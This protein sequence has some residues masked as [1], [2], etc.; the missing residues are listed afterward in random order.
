MVTPVS[1]AN[2]EVN[3]WLTL[4]DVPLSFITGDENLGAHARENDDNRLLVTSPDLNRL[5]I[6]IDGDLLR[7]AFYGYWLWHPYG[8]AGLY[9]MEV[10]RPGYPS[11]IAYI[12]VF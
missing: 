2:G 10:S 8:H 5:E 9:Q 4:N 1:G 11:Q 3:T 6:R 12:R 7:T